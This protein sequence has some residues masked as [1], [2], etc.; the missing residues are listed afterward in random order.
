MRRLRVIRWR[1]PTRAELRVLLKFHIGLS[2]CSE[3][4]TIQAIT[5]AGR[6]GTSDIDC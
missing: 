2:Q 4:P 3:L 5:P 1:L 6:Y